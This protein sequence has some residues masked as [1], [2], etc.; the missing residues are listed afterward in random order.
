MDFLEAF[1][2]GRFLCL[3]GPTGVGKTEVAIEVAESVGAEILSVDSRQVYRGMDIGTAKPTREQLSRIPHHLI[4]VVE[5][6]RELS[7]GRFGRMGQEVLSRLLADGKRVLVVGGSGLYLRALLGGFF[8]G[9]GRDAGIRRILRERVR[10]EGIESLHKALAAID[11]E[12]AARISP[13]DEQRIVRALEVFK[14]T[15]KPISEHQVQ[16]RVENEVPMIGITREREVLYRRIEE[17]VERMFGEGL[18]AEVESL[19]E[20][21]YAEARPFRK[22]VGYRELMDHFGGRI[23]LDEAKE[24]IKKNTRRY[25]KRQLTWFRG[26]ESVRWIQVGPSEDAPAVAKRVK[27]LWREMRG[28]V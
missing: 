26:I 21:G 17:R 12:A 15:G 4:G 16:G 20:M 10:S 14:L 8:E 13:R 7:A 18:P 23:S 9:P 2:S 22:T 27:R 1:R 3:V 24:L 25:A 19:M 28:R 5:P 11:P 6:T